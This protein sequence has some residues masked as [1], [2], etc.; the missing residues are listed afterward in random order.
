MEHLI[1]GIGELGWVA[2]KATLLYLTAVIGFR[3]CRQRAL[4]D[5]SAFDF[6]AAVAV[7]AIV[8]RVPNASDASYL[9]G[10]A[11]LVA[12]L[13]THALVTRLR[14][15]PSVAQ[16][17]ERSPRVLVA[18]GRVLDDELRRCGL[19]YRDLHAL[20]RERGVEDLDAVKYLIFEQRGRV[21]LVLDRRE[22]RAVG[23]GLF[24]SLAGADAPRR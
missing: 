19:T 10:A 18:S 22:A 1:G 24:A 23:P 16:V 17:M 21:S 6:V 14:R 3:L 4:A 9:A 12:V 20:L 7:G 13:A 5:L 2:A 11:T 15:F 8:G